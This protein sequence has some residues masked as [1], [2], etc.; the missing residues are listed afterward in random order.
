MERRQVEG[1]AGAIVLF[2]VLIF[3]GLIAAYAAVADYAQARASSDWPVV[4]GSVLSGDGGV[5]YA[6]FAE[7]RSHAGTRVRYWT[8]ALSPSGADYAPGDKV[9]VFVSPDDGAIG[10]LEPGGSPYLFALVLGFG[11]FLVFIGLAGV[12]RLTMKLDGLS[13]PRRRRASDFAP[14]E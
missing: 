12:I 5:R 8:A 7:G 14:A 10:V 13:A 9:K 11:G 6:W 4:D 3:T 2:G 1:A